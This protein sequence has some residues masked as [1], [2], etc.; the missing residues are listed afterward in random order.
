MQT[1]SSA[2]VMVLDA[3]DNMLVLTRSN[4]HPTRPLTPDLPGGKLD[5]LEEPGAAAV[6]EI[7]EETGLKV[8]PTKLHLIYSATEAWDHSYV[9]FLYVIKLDDSEPMVKLSFEHNAYSWQPIA[10]LPK[11]EKDYVSFY[12]DAFEYLAKNKIIESLYS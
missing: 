4:T 1:T 2:K 3:N 5:S 8:D 6:R 9:E 12:Q 11:I 7:F 10:N